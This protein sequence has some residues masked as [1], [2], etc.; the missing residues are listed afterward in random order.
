MAGYIPEMGDL[1]WLNFSPQLGHEQAGRRPAV[2]LTPRLYNQIGLLIACP[3]TSKAK[4]YPFEVPLPS[5]SKMQGVILADQ[6][7]SMDWRLRQAQKA[8]RIPTAVLEQ[9]RGMVAALLQFS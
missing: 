9:V 8:G 7:K 5:G 1:V 3:I 4:G 6:L 2:V